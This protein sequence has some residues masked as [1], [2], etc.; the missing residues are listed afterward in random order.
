MCVALMD[1]GNVCTRVHLSH[2]WEWGLG[3]GGWGGSNSEATGDINV[4]ERVK[5]GLTRMDDKDSTLKQEVTDG[6]KYK[7][8]E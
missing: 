3:R 2:S 6:G 1:M 8:Q 7:K 4:F 5:N